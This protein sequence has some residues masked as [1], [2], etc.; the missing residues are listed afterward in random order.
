MSD[1]DLIFRAGGRRRMTLALVGTA[2]RLVIEC[3]DVYEASVVFQD[4]RE[5]LLRGEKIVIGGE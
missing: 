3:G 4:I 5:R 2:V 1:V